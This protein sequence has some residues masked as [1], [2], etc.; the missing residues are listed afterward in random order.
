M[1]Y[2]SQEEVFKIMPN[3]GISEAAGIDNLPGELLK[4]GA[5]IITKT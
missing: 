4:D 3:I 1:S 5:E 2:F